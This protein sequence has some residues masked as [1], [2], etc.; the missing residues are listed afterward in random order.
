MFYMYIL[1]NEK[2]S[3]YIGTT[4]NIDKRIKQHNS[5]QS[6]YTRNRGPWELVYEEEFQSRSE[7]IKRE[8]YLKSQKSKK[9]LN[10]L[11][12]SKS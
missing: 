5:H 11:I 9:Y 4:N 3:F 12:D 6:N 7:A 2:D 8:Y 1:R 10:S